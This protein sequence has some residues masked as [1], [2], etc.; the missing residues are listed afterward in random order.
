MSQLRAIIAIV[1]MLLVVIIIVQNHVAMSTTVE[2]KV[3]LLFFK[4]ETEKME[5]YLV[6]LIA[7]MAGVIFTGSYGMFE[8][9]RLKKQINSLKKEAA[10]K[11]I[12]I[13][14]L[15]NLPVTENTILNDSLDDN[16]N[17]KKI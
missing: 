15:R 6:T 4:F 12:E 13:N 16:D 1:L 8:R 3:N 9:F 11:D 5:L 7:L 10:K 14:S 2:F 17:K